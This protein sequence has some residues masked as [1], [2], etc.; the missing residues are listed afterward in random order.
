MG[1]R[2]KMSTAN[3]RKAYNLAIQAAY[4]RG[5]ETSRILGEI[6]SLRDLYI[7][8]TI[9]KKDTIIKLG[10]FIQDNFKIIETIQKWDYQR[11]FYIPTAGTGS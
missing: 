9:T 6:R 2:S 3:Q 11:R 1:Q 5:V 7:S 4:S 8:K 10:R